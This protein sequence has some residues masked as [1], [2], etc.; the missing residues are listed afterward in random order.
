MTG[1]Q[2]EQGREQLISM[3]CQDVLAVIPTVTPEELGR[4]RGRLNLTSLTVLQS[5]SEYML[6]EA[7]GQAVRQ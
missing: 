7:Q 3:I 5:I 6:T 2:I 1:E 4:L